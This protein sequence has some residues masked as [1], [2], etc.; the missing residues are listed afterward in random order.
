V[1][2]APFRVLSPPRALVVALAV[3]TG[4]LAS[5]AADLVYTNNFHTVAAG[6]LYRSAQLGRGALAERIRMSGIK[7]ILNLRGAHPDQRW[8]QDEIA[9]ARAAHVAHYDYAL[10][11]YRPVTPK[12]IAD[13]VAI[14]RSAPAPMLVHCKS[15]ADRTGLVAALYRAVIDRAAPGEAAGELSPWYGHFPYL[16]SGTK[17]MDQSFEQI[18]RHAAPR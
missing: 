8:Y 13:I 12:A 6:R 5:Y 1:L 3:M 4:S 18:V 7:S 15:G 14:L 10:S 9:V 16:W 17:A 2:L 11:A